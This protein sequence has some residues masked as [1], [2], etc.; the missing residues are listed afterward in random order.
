MAVTYRFA[1]VA[2]REHERT[3]ASVIAALRLA[4]H[5]PWL[6]KTLPALAVDHYDLCAASFRGGTF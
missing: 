1:T 3:G 4:H 2:Q 6:R 5:R